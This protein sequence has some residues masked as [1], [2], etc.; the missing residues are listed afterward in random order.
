MPYVPS[1]DD[2]DSTP[3][4]FGPPLPR[5]RYKF[6][7]E[8]ANDTISSGGNDMIAL[9]LTVTEGEYE[10]RK[11][12]ENLVFGS[13]KALWRIKQFLQAVGLDDHGD[14]NIEGADIMGLELQATT[15]LEN[16]QGEPRAKILNYITPESAEPTAASA[17][18]PAATAKKPKPVS[19]GLPLPK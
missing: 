17:E 1:L 18:A 13:D 9:V 2:I 15:K 10:G 6:I 12:W 14:C 3:R 19:Q 11:V 16:Y 5:G 7:V 4:D 8:D